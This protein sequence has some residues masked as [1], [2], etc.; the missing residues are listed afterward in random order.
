M[1]L[2]EKQFLR[3][4]ATNKNKIHKNTPTTHTHIPAASLQQHPERHGDKKRD[5]EGWTHTHT[6]IHIDIS[7]IHVHTIKYILCIKAYASKQYTPT[8]THT[9]THT[10]Q[11]KPQQSVNEAAVAEIAVTKPMNHHT[12]HHLI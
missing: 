8:H 9:H 11:L 4:M 6:R 3:Q 7:F 1:R 5:G 12:Q 2:D 10:A